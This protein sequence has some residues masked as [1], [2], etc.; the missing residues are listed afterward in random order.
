MTLR[1]LTGSLLL[2]TLLAFA[3]L[4][5]AATPTDLAKKIESTY[6]ITIPPTPPPPARATIRFHPAAAGDPGI[7]RWLQRFD[8]EL[9]RYP[10]PLLRAT[11]LKKIALVQDLTGAGVWGAYQTEAETSTIYVNVRFESTGA[12]DAGN[13]GGKAD[14][15][16]ALRHVF[17]IA[18]G[19]LLD[20][21]VNGMLAQADPKWTLLN[22]GGFK[23]GSGAQTARISL[24]RDHRD[25]SPGFFSQYCTSSPI[26][27]KGELFACMMIPDEKALL[28]RQCDR[29]AVLSAKRKYVRGVIDHSS[30]PP[31]PA[32]EKAAKLARLLDLINDLSPRDPERGGSTPSERAEIKK[33]IDDVREVIDTRGWNGRS[34]LMQA[35]IQDRRGLINPLLVQTGA[36]IDLAD[37]DGWTALHAAA[38][39]GDE[40]MVLT[41]LSYGAKPNLKD[42][43]GGTAMDWATRRGF[44]AVAE[45]LRH[46]TNA[47][48]PPPNLPL[49]KQLH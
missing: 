1:R 25:A 32:D 6:G 27:D 2:A 11:G 37:E 7:A 46:A 41:L 20:A 26:A 35:A 12:A 21:R 15:E 36:D 19:Q 5:G 10:A 40:P 49:R 8:E 44:K 38:F 14:L 33:L 42:R 3:T 29:D 28:E 18:L 45:R 47:P 43:Y 9:A 48:T 34:V 31:D 17:H 30:K 16:W 13:A 22:A 4:S 23:Y 39:I 24:Q